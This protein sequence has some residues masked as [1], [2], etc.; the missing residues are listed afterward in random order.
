MKFNLFLH[1][2]LSDK[3]PCPL[4]AL[5]KTEAEGETWSL[6]IGAART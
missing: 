2:Y 5:G 4:E 1:A 6:S 3:V